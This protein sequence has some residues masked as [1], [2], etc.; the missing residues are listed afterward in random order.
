MADISKINPDGGLTVYDLKDAY[1]RGLIP[2]NASS[3]NKLATM[4]DIGGG[5]VSIKASG[6]TSVT[7]N[8]SFSLS[9]VNSGD[10]VVFTARDSQN[11]PATAVLPCVNNGSNTFSL[12]KGT[13][14][15]SPIVYANYNSTGKTLTFSTSEISITLFYMHLGS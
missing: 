11:V 14:S 3:S 13:S 2:S 8:R 15:S 10:V 12:Y 1:V 7:S 4:A 5:G 9:N 6:Q